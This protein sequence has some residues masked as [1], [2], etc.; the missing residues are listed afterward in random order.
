[1]KLNITVV[2]VVF[3]AVFGCQTK[4]PIPDSYE[5]EQ[6]KVERLTENTF[7]HISFLDTESSGRVECN[8]MI[9][10]DDGEALI[11]DTP[12]DNATSK[13]LIEWVENELNSEVVGVIATHFH[14]D[15]IGGLQQFHQS[16][17]PSYA[18]NRTL[19]LAKT[20][21]QI[22][23]KNG[24]KDYFEIQVGNKKVINV[25]LGE[26]HTQ[27]N[28]ISYFP[29]EKVLFGGCLIKSNGA[30]KG[31]LADANIGEWS[32]TV[33]KVKSNYAEAEVIIPGHGKVGGLELLDYTIEMFEEN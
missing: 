26:G 33:Q 22:L 23:P 30:G 9:V 8:G 7:V 18:N 19:E 27:D 2:L 3:T 4:K 25:R 5:S 15:C 29:D 17:I 1:M 13:E 16:E 24:F 32:K 12:A 10:I 14:V 21:T 28:I 11:F 31:N 6:L 20:E